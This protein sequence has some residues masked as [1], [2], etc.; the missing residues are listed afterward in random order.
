MSERTGYWW[1]AQS[2]FLDCSGGVSISSYCTVVQDTC[3]G[4][5]PNA[6]VT[7]PGTIIVFT[8]GTLLNLLFVLIW[9]AEAPYNL[10]F[11]LLATDG[12]FWALV[13]RTVEPKNR[14]TQFH[15]CFIPLAIVSVSCIAFAAA[16]VEMEYLHGLSF[17]TMSQLLAQRALGAGTVGPR[18]PMGTREDDGIDPTHASSDDDPKKRKRSRFFSLMHSEPKATTRRLL[19]RSITAPGGAGKAERA[20]KRQER[21]DIKKEREKELLGPLPGAMDDVKVKRMVWLPTTVSLIYAI[22]LVSWV[23]FFPVVFL[24]TATDDPWQGHCSDEFNLRRFRII[25]AAMVA[26][27]VLIT[28]IFVVILLW[29]FRPVWRSQNQSARDVLSTIGLL[30]HSFGRWVRPGKTGYSRTREN[31]RWSMALGIYTAWVACYLSVYFMGLNEFILMGDNPWDFGQVAACFGTL[32]PL[33]VVAR[34]LFDQYDGWKGGAEIWKKMEQQQRMLSD[35]VD[36]QEEE[37][38]EMKKQ[39]EKEEKKE[40]KEKKSRNP[41]KRFRKPRTPSPPPSPVPHV[42]PLRPITLSGIGDRP[43]SFHVDYDPENPPPLLPPSRHPLSPPTSHRRGSIT[44]HVA[45]ER[46][47]GSGRRHSTISSVSSASSA[48]SYHPVIGPSLED[49]NDNRYVMSG[50]RGSPSPSPS[51]ERR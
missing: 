7:G 13:D 14:L 25:I 46:A 16:T 17:G 36:E 6:P 27:F 15:A 47:S 21:R 10:L 22:H 4:L 48:R 5:C 50:G 51:P 24:H 8:V 23:I 34:A 20:K 44:S 38:E 19:P 1:P 31:V 35:A 26:S 11:Q 42:P 40:K 28:A 32:G 49:L 30:W 18:V 43:S 29:G 45:D 41:I 9:K 37:L 2:G 12:A 39:V 3:C 33:C